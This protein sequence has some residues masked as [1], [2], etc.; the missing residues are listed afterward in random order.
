MYHVCHTLATAKDTGKIPEMVAHGEPWPGTH[1]NREDYG[2]A[3]A[4]RSIWRILS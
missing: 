3:P 2:V 1:P 4:L